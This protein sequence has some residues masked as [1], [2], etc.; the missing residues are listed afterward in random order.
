V[1]G[2]AQSN[3]AEQITT[4]D[5]VDWQRHLPK[6]PR[7]RLDMR[8]KLLAIGFALSSLFFF[9]SQAQSADSG[10]PKGKLSTA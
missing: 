3:E 6:A 5:T 8:T 1:A 2:S 7:R 10:F 4:A 9:Q